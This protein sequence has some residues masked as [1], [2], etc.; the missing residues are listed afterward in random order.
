MDRIWLEHYP[1]GVPAEIDI[2]EYASVR[3]IFEEACRKFGT[4][5]AFSCMGR[6]I[7]FGDLDALSSTFGA[8]LQGIGCAKGDARRADDAQYPPVPGVP[9]RRAA[10]RMHGGQR[11]SALHGARARASARRFWRRGHRR[12]RE[13]RQYAA[14][15]RRAY[16]D[17]ADGGDVDRRNAGRQG[18]HRRPHAAPGEKGGAEVF[19]ARRDPLH[20]CDEARPQAVDDARADR[21]RRP[22]VPAVHGRHD[23]HCQ[24]RDAA[25]PEHRREHAAGARVGAPDP[26]RQPARSDHDAAAALSHLRADGELPRLHVG[27]RRERADHEPARHPALRQGD[28]P[29]PVHGDDGRQHAVQRAAQQSEVRAAQLQVVP[30]DARRRHGGPGS[31]RQTLE[32]RHG[33]HARR[34][35]WPHR[36]VAGRDDEPA[37]C[38]RIHRRDRPADSVDRRR[39]ARRRGTGRA[40]RRSGRDLHPRSAG[41]GRLLAAAG[42]NREGHDAGRVLHERRH[43]QD[44]SRAATSRSSIARRT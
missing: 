37:R 23:G 14:A 25:A 20:R 19:A 41:D 44:G 36:N 12:R 6:S 16:E 15:S 26:R 35:L 32:G 28:A 22:R 2:S 40:A 4:R 42:R 27:R 43:R 24:G 8:W 5:P 33:R 9:V 1:R 29:L 10:R 3:E 7:T 30:A 31:G 38:R 39:V 21:S 13:F 18:T 34:S 17:P 11:Q